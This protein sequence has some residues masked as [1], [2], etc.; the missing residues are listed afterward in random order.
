MASNIT[1]TVFSITAFGMYAVLKEDGTASVETTDKVTFLCSTD[2]PKAV[3]QEGMRALR[4]VG[5]K[6]KA[7][8]VRYT[9]DSETV[10]AMTLETFL[11]N[12]KPVTRAAG[13][14]VKASDLA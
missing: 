10:Y 8:D 7:S 6:V 14:Y 2:S 12:A 5:I 9:I 3:K 1:R 4:E 11:A 13:G